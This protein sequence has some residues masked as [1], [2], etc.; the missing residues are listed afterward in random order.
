VYNVKTLTLIERP[1]LRNDFC[2]K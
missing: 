1:R 2:S